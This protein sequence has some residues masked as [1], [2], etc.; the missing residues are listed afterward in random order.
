M[1]K[2]GKVAGILGSEQNG[3]RRKHCEIVRIHYVGGTRDKELFI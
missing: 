3:Y 1:N 2:R